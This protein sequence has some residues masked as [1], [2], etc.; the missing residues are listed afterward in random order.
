MEILL[1]W[2]AGLLISISVYLL[3]NKNLVRV[4]FGVILM[5][6]S[7]N[8]ILFLSGNLT[9][10]IPAFIPEGENLPPKLFANPLPQA[11][12]LT[13]IVIGF[14]VI[15]Y[16]LVLIT[17]AWQENGS[18]NSDNFQENFRNLENDE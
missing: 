18:M 4:L 13:A 16:G 2:L 11:L 1:C 8:L 14:G 6:T 9:H 10:L 7:I 3:L 5:S 17:Q 15:A 12:M